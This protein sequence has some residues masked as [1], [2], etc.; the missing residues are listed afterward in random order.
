MGYEKSESCGNFSDRLYRAYPCSWFV[1][2]TN[3]PTAPWVQ[4]RVYTRD[5]L[6]RLAHLDRDSDDFDERC[7][8]E[9]IACLSQFSHDAADCRLS[10]DGS[11]VLLSGSDTNEIAYRRITNSGGTIETFTGRIISPTFAVNSHVV[12]GTFEGTIEAWSLTAQ[13]DK[14]PWLAQ[15][16]DWR[17]VYGT[18][19]LVLQDAKHAITVGVAESEIEVW[20]VQK[21][22][23]VRKLPLATVND[24]DFLDVKSIC[25]SKK[26]NRIVVGLGSGG[27]VIVDLGLDLEEPTIVY[28]FSTDN[29]RP[30]RIT[31]RV[32]D[33]VQ[34]TMDPQEAS[35]TATS[36]SGSG[37]LL[38]VGNAA[39][40]VAVWDGEP[41]TKWVREI[42][43]GCVTAVRLSQDERLIATA[44]EDGG[45]HVIDASTGEV[46][47]TFDATPV[48]GSGERA[49][50]IISI[51]F[52]SD[53]KRLA[54]GSQQGWFRW[55]DR[56]E[57]CW[58]SVDRRPGRS[59][60]ERLT[61]DQPSGFHVS[62]CMGDIVVASWATGKECAWLPVNQPFVCK[63]SS[64][65]AG[66][67]FVV[68]DD[69]LRFY[70]R[71][72]DG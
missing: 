72:G 49:D 57:G 28:P 10:S 66:D 26:E 71:E 27:V 46:I 31:V 25:A 5:A 16:K 1:K 68:L 37:G 63:C 61:E 3:D 36:I 58:T 11:V 51:A 52:S 7:Y 41:H 6:E 55:L 30:E 8:D 13:E 22:R 69:C 47:E 59:D 56:E 29:I 2:P 32:N 33:E 40:Q 4:G 48:V 45:I 18:Q 35:V 24:G 62:Q 60:F 20:D 19:L 17:A 21:A 53:G 65:K 43:E 67:I 12:F 70:A 44:G 42:H 50:R 39:G 23:C 14:S 34:V 15:R 64:D 38:L 54:C 9:A